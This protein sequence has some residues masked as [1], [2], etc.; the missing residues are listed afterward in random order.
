MSVVELRRANLEIASFLKGMEGVEASCTKQDE[1]ITFLLTTSQKELPWK[2]IEPEGEP[3]KRHPGDPPED[4][5]REDLR[6]GTEDLRH[7]APMG[8]EATIVGEEP[9]NEPCTCRATTS[10]SASDQG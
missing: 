4:S 6:P 2:E 3:L 10:K 5:D 8:E 7:G 9:T 1:G